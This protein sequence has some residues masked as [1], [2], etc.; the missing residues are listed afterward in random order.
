MDKLC[1]S[2]WAGFITRAVAQVN[3]VNSS[4]V[5][6]TSNV[7]FPHSHGGYYGASEGPEVKQTS[8]IT[9]QFNRTSDVITTDLEIGVDNNWI[10]FYSYESEAPGDTIHQ[11]RLR[12][13]IFRFSETKADMKFPTGSGRKPR[14]A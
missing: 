6:S 1:N 7:R 10:S 13:R 4:S 9:C 14:C 2:Y 11:L 12:H 5:V 3:G 8:Q